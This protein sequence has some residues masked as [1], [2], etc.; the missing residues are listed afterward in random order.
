MCI[1]LGAGSV[2][3]PPVPLDES[4]KDTGKALA[5]GDGLRY[6]ASVGENWT[7]RECNMD[8]PS[9]IIF[10][11]IGDP[12]TGL[13][14]LAKCPGEETPE[15]QFWRLQFTNWRDC[16]AGDTL[17]VSRAVIDCAL[18]NRSPP[19]WLQKASV[20][21]GM[22]CMS[23][24]EKRAR[25]AINKH[26]HCWKAVKLVRGRHPNDP[27]NF[28]TMVQGDAVWAEAAKLM[29]DIDTEVDAET[30]RKSYQL[31][32]RAGGSQVTL[33]SYKRE[34]AKRDRHRKKKF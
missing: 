1:D 23:D 5:L 27:R 22:Q 11:L 17:A 7:Q 19:F 31:I 4:S 13:A 2:A 33:P 21:L 6:F 15:R 30:M 8:Q 34:V 16:L 18:F 12:E 20:T 3:Y 26:W 28:K 10:N 25:R 14:L 32:E 29:A 24:A 9:S